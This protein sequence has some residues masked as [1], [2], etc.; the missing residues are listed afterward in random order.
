MATERLRI[1]P[2]LLDAMRRCAGCHDQCLTAT[3]E[4]A[5]SGDQTRV[6]S[7]VATLGLRLEDGRLSW[8]RDVA[9][10]LFFGLGDGLQAEYCIYGSEGQRIE[11]YLHALRTSAVDRG[12][13]PTSVADAAGAI[14]TSGNVFGSGLPIG[15]ERPGP[16]IL[17]HDAATAALAPE[18]PASAR[19][20]LDRAGL[21]GS[22]RWI[23]SSGA[24]EEEVGLV[25]A[26]L[27][28]GADAVSQIASAGSATVVSADP[29][30]VARLRRLL[31]PSSAPT[32]ILHLAEALGETQTAF[33]VRRAAVAVHDDGASG[34]RLGIAASVRGLLGRVPGLVLREPVNSGRLA[35]SDGPLAAYPDASLAAAIARRRYLELERTGADTIITLSPY[36][37]ANL[38]AVATGPRVVDLAVF[39]DGLGEGE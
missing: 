25:D 5:A 1:A 30:L 22:D 34:R 12:L 6:V 37:L 10:A 2:P 20:L 18:V 17:L 26:A 16:T 14:R 35:A 31:A 27:A 33:G 23:Q 3:A 9:E 13:A 29:V 15:T 24:I 39:L 36:S 19:R 4:A 38:R 8:D 32:R 7:R 21:T 28:A 11:P